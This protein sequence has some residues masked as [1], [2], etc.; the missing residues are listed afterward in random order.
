VE[1]RCG[2]GA[3]RVRGVESALSDPLG[4]AVLPAAEARAARAQEDEEWLDIVLDVAFILML[5]AATLALRKFV[6]SS[7]VRLPKHLRK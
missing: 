4:L 7:T 3:R 5:V 6:C 1:R 2:L